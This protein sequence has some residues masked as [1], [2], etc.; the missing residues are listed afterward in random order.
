MK[1][2]LMIGGSQ[3][4]RTSPVQ[5]FNTPISFCN[6]ISPPERYHRRVFLNPHDND[7]VQVW[8]VYVTDNYLSS[9]CTLTRDEILEALE[10]KGIKPH[11]PSTRTSFFQCELQVPLALPTLSEGSA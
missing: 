4:L 1:T 9:N 8:Y 5:G 7:F 6:G 3:H 10:D 11:F 2:V